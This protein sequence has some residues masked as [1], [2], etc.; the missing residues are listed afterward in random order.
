MAATL[1][2]SPTSAKPTRTIAALLLLEQAPPGAALPGAAP[3]GAF[4]QEAPY[5]GALRNRL[6]NR[7]RNIGRRE[8]PLLMRLRP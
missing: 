1:T 8:P 6:R 5:G 4:A 2:C 3:P 7:L